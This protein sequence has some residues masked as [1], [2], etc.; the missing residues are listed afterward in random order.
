M[1]S[2]MKSSKD[3][4][5]LLKKNILGSIA[6]KVCTGI[7]QFLSVPVTLE[8]LTQYEYGIWLI[9]SSILIWIDQFDIGLGNGLKNKL[10]EALANN[11][12]QKARELVSTAFIMLIL[13]VLP[14]M[15]LCYFA[16][17]NIDLYDILNINP[18]IVPDLYD[19]IYITFSI[20]CMTFIFKFIGSTYAGL[21]LPAISNLLTLLGQTLA[22]VIIYIMS[23]LGSS[24]L[25][26]VSIAYTISP[27]I[28]YIF[29]YP[30][31]F[32]RYKYLKPSLY[33]FSKNNLKELFSLGSGFFILQIASLFIFASSN[34]IIAKVL[35]PSEVT[36]Y[37]IAYRFFN[38]PLML[39]TL[40]ITPF[41]AATTDAY[42]KG[43]WKWIN[44]MM[45][46]M[47]KVIICFLLL[48]F[49]MY[50]ISPYVYMLWVGTEININNSLS[51]CMALYIMII[52][53][54]SCYSNF[55]Y[56]TGKI[57]LI[58]IMTSVEAIIFIPLAYFLG[59]EYGLLGILLSLI[60]VN[61]LCLVT[62]KIQFKRISNGT[63]KGLWNK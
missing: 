43:D 44:K 50:F 16:I 18:K 49:V 2:K 59:R 1:N 37:Q 61:L 26:N 10:A 45:T 46:H 38:L 39:F 33:S 22:L 19:I 47:K 23:M 11:D 52:I 56:G 29:S 55:I 57:R 35:S 27:L 48:I 31:T 6:I 20:V 24:T 9:I 17:G 25:F 63:A 36:P 41:W 5:Y 15:L 21:Q 30:I 34:L 42:T 32:A 4:T 28:I 13:L 40:I 53:Y 3:R 62:N 51:A 54:S 58:T 12:P 7:V 14:I 8:C 60:S